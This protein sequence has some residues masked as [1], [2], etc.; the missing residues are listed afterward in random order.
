MSD[1]TDG[2]GRE[3]VMIIPTEGAPQSAPGDVLDLPD[4]QVLIVDDPADPLGTALR[5]ARERMAFD[6]AERK[7]MGDA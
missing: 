7:P 5:F 1:D 3:R 2:H 6:L 4:G